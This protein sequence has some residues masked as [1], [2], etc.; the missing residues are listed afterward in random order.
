MS[1]LNSAYEGQLPEFQKAKHVGETATLDG[2][3]CIA[4]MDPEMNALVFVDAHGQ[5][6]G[7]QAAQYGIMS[8]DRM[9]ALREAS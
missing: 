7:A 9:K 5:V 2:R 3:E 6:H 8:W 4:V 1:W